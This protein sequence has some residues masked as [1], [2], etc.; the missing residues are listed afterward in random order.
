M[1]K[2]FF[3]S[4]MLSFVALTGNAQEW[5]RSG[6]FIGLDAYC[7]LNGYYIGTSNG[8][9]EYSS[10]NKMWIRKGLQGFKVFSLYHE[11]GTVNDTLLAGT[12]RGIYYSP[13]RGATWT[14]TDAPQNAFMHINHKEMYSYNRFWYACSDNGVYYADADLKSWK[15]LDLQGH[16]VANYV[17]QAADTVAV[18]ACEQGLVLTG[19]NYGTKNKTAIHGITGVVD[20]VTYWSGSYNDSKQ[21][22]LVNKNSLYVTNL[23]SLYF[24]KTNNYS[25]EKR[26]T[27]P[28]GSS[29]TWIHMFTKGN[30]S[31]GT[32]M[33]VYSSTD[34][35]ITVTKSSSHDNYVT[36]MNYP[37]EGYTGYSD[38]YYTTLGTGFYKSGT[39]IGYSNIQTLQ[40][41]PDGSMWVGTNGF[42]VFK[43]DNKGKAW[44]ELNSGLTSLD[45]RD[46]EFSSNGDVYLATRDGAFMSTNKGASWEPV[47]PQNIGLFSILEAHPH[48]GITLFGTANSS[49]IRLGSDFNWNGGVNNLTD[50]IYLFRY[51]PKMDRYLAAGKAG[52]WVSETSYVAW[53]KL[54]GFPS[55]SIFDLEI[56]TEGRILALTNSAVY[57][58][59]NDGVDWQTTEHIPKNYKKDL[60]IDSKGNYYVATD[61]GVYYSTDRGLS[62][63]E[64]NTGLANLPYSA[65]IDCLELDNEN[66]LWAGSTASGLYRTTQPVT[67]VTGLPSNVLN[68]GFKVSYQPQNAKIYVFTNEVMNGSHQL[69][70]YSITGACVLSQAVNL[71]SGE[72]QLE[73]DLPELVSGAYTFRLTGQVGTVKG[74][75]LK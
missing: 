30:I 41:A 4:W 12:N 33:G 55:Y 17:G 2:T 27:V 24:S 48:D 7:S 18:F 16:Q 25:W 64:L 32:S 38:Y 68:S 63:K 60:V 70:V 13:D 26:W 74:K 31:I 54:M 42:G 10:V 8:L 62:W 71:T 59:D 21:A 36:S 1:K 65:L 45:V 57:Y 23:D 72:K 39:L 35:G 52:L 58:S 22:L 3:F 49:F 46:I 19:K 29:I 28:D 66:Y 69:S 40:L 15:L 51:H 9:L 5:E 6:D 56:D 67:P 53:K 20:M 37:M 43:L 47:K 75:F 73:I 61:G 44:T 11:T 34:R 50:D 14:R